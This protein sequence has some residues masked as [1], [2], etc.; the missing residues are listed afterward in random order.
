MKFS[1]KKD[2]SAV[3]TYWEALTFALHCFLEKD[4]SKLHHL[5]NI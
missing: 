4:I 2:L 1:R 5:I 3:N